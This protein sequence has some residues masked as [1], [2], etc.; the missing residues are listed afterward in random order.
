LNEVFTRL[1]QQQIE[2][3]SMRN[4]VNRLEELF[5][6]LVEQKPTGGAP[7]GAAHGHGRAHP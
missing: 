5:M 7:S 6:S 1:S 3:V 2:V 4:K